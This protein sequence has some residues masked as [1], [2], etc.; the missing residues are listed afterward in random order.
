M[1]YL[2]LF[3]LQTLT[4]LYDIKRELQTHKLKV[5]RGMKSEEVH[6]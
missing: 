6:E 4:I 1:S 3:Y 5:E 2:F